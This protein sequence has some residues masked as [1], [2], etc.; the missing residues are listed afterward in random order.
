MVLLVGEESGYLAEQNIKKKTM[1][2]SPIY[3]G[4]Q[5]DFRGDSLKFQDEFPLSEEALI[6]DA[7][8]WKEPDIQVSKDIGKI[9]RG[10]NVFEFKSEKDYFSTDDYAK[11]IGYASF[12]AGLKSVPMTDVTISIVVTMFPREAVRFLEEERG[13]VVADMGD[14]IHYVRGEI[15]PVQIL[16]TKALS[17]NNLFLKNLRSNLTPAELQETLRALEEAGV[18]DKRDAYLECIV[19]AN[20]DAFREVVNMSESLKELFLETAE[21]DGWLDDWGNRKVKNRDIE[22]ARGL[23]ADNVPVRVIVKNTGLTSQEVE[24]L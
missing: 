15:Y 20:W 9:F 6:I 24:A 18:M 5:L 13:L 16:E 14:G 1:W 11:A 4:L 21:E 10:H 22:I 3:R 7:L 12:Y 23:K 8:V 19:K 2:H 17:R